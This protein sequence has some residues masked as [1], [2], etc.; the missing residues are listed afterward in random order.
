VQTHMLTH[1][2]YAYKL[3]CRDASATH[4]CILCITNSG[5]RREGLRHAHLEGAAGASASTRCST[6]PRLLPPA[7]RAHRN[8]NGS[9]MTAAERQS[10]NKEGGYHLRQHGGTCY[11]PVHL[12]SLGGAFSVGGGGEERDIRRTTW[13]RWRKKRTPGRQ[14]KWGKERR[15]QHLQRTIQAAM[16]EKRID[17]RARCQ[18]RVWSRQARVRRK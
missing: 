9:V 8:S 3:K 18:E 16:S 10:R 17:Q 4:L 12:C 1:D 6:E 13:I 5:R 2:M 15:F 11:Q 7:A 14:E